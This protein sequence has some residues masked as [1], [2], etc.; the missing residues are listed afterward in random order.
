M[1]KYQ[2]K[3]EGNLFARAVVTGPVG[4]PYFGGLF[5]FDIMFPSLYPEDPPLVQ[6]NT[7]NGVSVWEVGDV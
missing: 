4:T 6:L 2:T 3:R 5:I 7:T 1:L